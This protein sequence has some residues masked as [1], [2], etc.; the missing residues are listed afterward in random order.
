MIKMALKGILKEW[1][2]IL[3]QILIGAGVIVGDM[4]FEYYI[5][6]A[7]WNAT[8]AGRAILIALFDIIVGIPVGFILLWIG[9]AIIF[10][11]TD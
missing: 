5:W 1:A 2:K 8:G 3:P 4:Y 7:L 11:G 10:I 9:F 6:S